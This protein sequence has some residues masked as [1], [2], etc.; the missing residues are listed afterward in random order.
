MPIYK[1]TCQ[2]KKYINIST[3]K[4]QNKYTAKSVDKFLTLIC[5][6]TLTPSDYFLTVPQAPAKIKAV[7]GGARSVVVSWAAPLRTHG[8]IT[9]Y[10]LYTRAPPERDPSRRILPPQV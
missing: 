5:L 6:I 2:I 4:K 10:I 3:D 9:K 1:S 8:I 7:V